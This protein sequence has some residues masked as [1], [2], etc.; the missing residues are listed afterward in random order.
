MGYKEMYEEWLNNP[1][2]DDATKAELKA[3][4]EAGAFLV[5]LFDFTYGQECLIYKSN[6]FESDNIIYIPD[7]DLNDI[8]TE[9]VL[10]DEEIEKVLHC[11]YTGTDF[12][13]ECSNHVDLAKELF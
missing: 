13:K 2:F 5:D 8:D 10:E 12:V 6:K 11:C 9:S 1:Y 3:K 4:L 7:V